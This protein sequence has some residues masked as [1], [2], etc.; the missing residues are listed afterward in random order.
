METTEVEDSFD[1][2][3]LSFE[4]INLINNIPD[5]SLS[6]EFKN[7]RLLESKFWSGNQPIVSSLPLPKRYKGVSCAAL[8]SD[9]SL[10]AIGT[11]QGDMA[12]WNLM[13]YPPRILAGCKG[14][15]SISQLQWSLDTS[16]IVTINQRGSIQLW[17][18]AQ[19]GS[20][21]DIKPF[22][23]FE[24]D[25]FQPAQLMCELTLE[26][27]DLVFTQGNLASTKNVIS[28]PTFVVF[29]PS[30]TF[31]G[32]QECL[33]VGL[34]SGNVLKLNL[35]EKDSY[36]STHRVNRTDSVNQV[37]KGI[38]AELFKAHKHPIK[39]I[40]FVDNTSQMVTVD[41]EGFINLWEYTEDSLSGYGWFT[42]TSSYRLD[43]IQKTY[44]PADGS[45]EK[46]E[47]IDVVKGTGRVKE[48]NRQDMI[49]KRKQMQTFI[50]SLHLGKPWR[51]T[52]AGS[53]KVNYLYAPRGVPES[54]ATFHSVTYHRE[55]KLLAQYSTQLYRP[56]TVKATRI[57]SCKANPLGNR[58]V[59]ALLFDEV[60]PKPPHVV[61]LTIDLSSMKVLSN[62]MEVPLS[63]A[64]YRQCE[65]DDCCDFDISRLI[66]A[67]GSPY[68]FTNVCG[69]V[70]SFSMVTTN[71]VMASSQKGWMGCSLSEEQSMIFSTARVVVASQD[72]GL[73]VVFYAPKINTVSLLHIKDSNSSETRQRV[74]QAFCRLTETSEGTH[75][76]ECIRRHHWTLEGEPTCHLQCTMESLVLDLVD[77][78]IKQSLGQD[79]SEDTEGVNKSLENRIRPFL[80]HAKQGNNVQGNNSSPH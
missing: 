40:S 73:C 54:G 79:G 49:A 63:I 30:L 42:P 6:I 26:P 47:F 59:L 53:Q 8:S 44:K 68:M 15:S 78:A 60:P 75:P 13:V 24:N 77:H 2:K 11:F 38:E 27:K 1:G 80:R 72:D 12:L 7:Y 25:G 50:N 16:Q 52:D 45:S 31:L 69:T 14:N 62:V 66:D 21:V 37:G 22:E 43:M 29:H 39:H 64:D 23:P 51:I 17:S 20:T 67:T 9:H 32:R 76:R 70:G 3:I 5:H 10:L 65:V 48:L 58:L 34:A 18:I 41:D 55:S 33:I 61:F 74:W 71:L 36:S 56:I 46:V 28:R 35:S 4:G 19:G 57:A